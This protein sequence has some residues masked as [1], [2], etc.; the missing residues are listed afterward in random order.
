[1]AGGQ[2]AALLSPSWEGAGKAGASWKDELQALITVPQLSQPC[3]SWFLTPRGE[4]TV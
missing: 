3:A 1:M 2:K 4:R